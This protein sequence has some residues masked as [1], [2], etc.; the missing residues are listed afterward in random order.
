MS[1]LNTSLFAKVVRYDTVT[2]GTNAAAIRAL[3]EGVELPAGT[4][5]RADAQTAGRGQG[6]NRW[7]ATPAANLLLSLIAYPDHLSVHRLFV[8]TQLSGLAVADTVRAFLPPDLANTVRLKWPNDVYV[9]KRKIAGILVQN[10]LR[11]SAISWSVLGIGLNV[12]ETNFPPEL[13]LSATSL[14]LLLGSTVDREAVLATLLANLS[15]CYQLSQPAQLSVLEARYAQQLYRLNEPG[16]Y[17]D[18][19]TGVSFFAILRGVNEAGQ[20]RLEMAE[21]G[22]R[23]FSLREVQFI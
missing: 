18:T 13:E 2:D 7:H 5:F 6:S 11:G 12:N 4:V 15:A 8:L 20:L 16:R 14:A 3:A 22:E 19:A 10:G 23:V 1:K 9:G 21:G 17:R